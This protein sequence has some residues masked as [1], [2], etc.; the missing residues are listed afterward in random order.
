VKG[1]GG[2]T[3]PH[4]SRVMLAELENDKV[5]RR[6]ALGREKSIARKNYG[7][8][9]DGSSLEGQIGMI[10]RYLDLQN[11][12]WPFPELNAVGIFV[13]RAALF[14][15]GDPVFLSFTNGS[16]ERSGASAWSSKK[17][18]P[19]IAFHLAHTK[20]Q[21]VKE[22][23]IDWQNKVTVKFVETPDEL[24]SL[25]SADPVVRRF[26]IQTVRGLQESLCR[27]PVVP[28]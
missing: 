22:N 11:W 9:I 2:E 15:P 26:V 5:A 1:Y 24:T 13:K 16:G 7:K 28:E 20:S 12:P 27:P 14:M 19:I 17:R 10:F 23:V 18:C 6:A 4:A 3:I 25:S 21:W 8:K